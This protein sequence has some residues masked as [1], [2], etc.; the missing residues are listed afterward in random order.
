MSDPFLY[1]FPSPLEGY[2]DYAPLSD[3]LNEDGKSFKNPS[4][5]VLSP[6]YERFTSGITN[7]RRGGFDVHVYYHHNSEVQK[8]FAKALWQRIRLEFPELR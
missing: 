8:E 2:E 3:E 4:T 6:S 1:T 5:G 7:D